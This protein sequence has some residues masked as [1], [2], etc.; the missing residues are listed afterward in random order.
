MA[1][2]ETE[3]NQ[4]YLTDPE[5]K[6]ISLILHE[7]RL[8][9]PLHLFVILELTDIKKKTETNEL[10]KISEA[11]LSCFRENQK[12]AP[13]NLF[14]SA[15]ARINDSLASIAHKGSKAWLGKLSALI[16]LK[17]DSEIFVANN[18]Q[19]AAWLKRKSDLSQILTPD[20]KGEE[21]LKIFQ[22]FAHGRI[23]EQD[24]LIITTTSLFNFI[25]LELLTKLL[26]RNDLA[27]AA[28][29]VSS[30]LQESGGSNNA[31]AAF[32][33]NF[34]T[35]P[36]VHIQEPENTKE[37]EIAIVK[38]P[39]GPV[40]APMPEDIPKTPLLPKLPKFK[41]PQLSSVRLPKLVS[42]RRINIAQ[43]GKLTASAKFFLISFLVFALIFAINLIVLGNRSFQKNG[44]E[45]IDA[46]V[47]L[48]A[49][50]MAEAESAL[51]YK[52][53]D[54]SFRLLAETKTEVE[55][56]KTMDE[57]AG[58][59]MERR[60]KIL[61]DRIN[62]I[63]NVSNPKTMI[64][65]K[66]SPTFM[67]RAGNGY[68]F[69]SGNT[70]TLS[71]Y[72]PPSYDSLFL[73]NSAEGGIR[74]LAHV[75]SNGNWVLGADKIY[76]INNTDKQL[77][78][79][80]S[81]ANG[82]LFG[83]K[84]LSPNRIYVANKTNN[85][86]QRFT[87]TSGRLSTPVN[88]LKTNTNLSELK[89]FGVDTD[90]YLLYSDGI[91]KF[92][93]GNEQLFKIPKLSEPMTEATKMA[94]GSNLYIL[95]PAKKRLIMIGKNGQLVNQIVFTNAI[96]LTDFYVDETQRTINLIDSNKLIEITF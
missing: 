85:Q 93:N 42:F 36:I 34:T 68:L 14:E 29:E 50:T 5:S 8:R 49:Q 52:N 61:S 7:E 4:I 15:L 35:A 66:H 48:I 25:S 19:T 58:S 37:K 90:V 51:I 92:V 46:Q 77:D 2:L 67:A 78:Q 91:K 56:L 16:A 72:A 87:L 94:V 10:K 45:K 82:N 86:I 38:E 32:F 62:R 39:T 96:D 3:I 70:D 43:F 60:Y 69:S 20:K 9:D 31:F 80:S 76:R 27:D 84:F 71:L 89:D 41:L 53:D 13:A 59:E 22:N 63:T 73:L 21:P 17:S 75:P 95:E 79:I 28:K 30:I 88:I 12:M 57:E 65:L 64:D 26:G 11:I 23:R 54:Q 55:E 24:G 40:Y 33:L 47:E 18:G 83:I 81:T 74:G 44:Q 1:K 6:K